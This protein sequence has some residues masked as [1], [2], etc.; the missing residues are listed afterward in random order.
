MK[1]LGDTRKK[2]THHFHLGK[3]M[4]VTGCAWLENG[5]FSRKYEKSK[6]R[7]KK[8]LGDLRGERLTSSTGTL[9]LLKL[10]KKIPT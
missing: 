8:V 9:Q 2:I 4:K 5:S 1:K 7:G 6:V 3:R 10:R